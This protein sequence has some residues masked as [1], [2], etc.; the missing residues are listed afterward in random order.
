MDEKETVI[1]CLTNTTQHNTKQNLPFSNKGI[2]DY[3]EYQDQKALM[4]PSSR[5][6]TEDEYLK[7]TERTKARLPPTRQRWCVCDSRKTKEVFS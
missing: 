7:E 5:M 2:R 3:V 1:W 4:I 6:F